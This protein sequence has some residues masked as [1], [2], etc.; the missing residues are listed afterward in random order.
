MKGTPPRV[1]ESLGE[2]ECRS[3]LATAGFGRLIFT[4][5]ALPVVEPVRFGIRRGQI[6]IPTG[7][8]DD[9]SPSIRGAV[10]AFEVDCLDAESGTGW[11][12]TA[13]GPAHVLTDEDDIADAERLELQPWVPSVNC[14]FVAVE[15][16]LLRGRRVSRVTRTAPSLV[17]G[18]LPQ[19]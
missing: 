18:V 15:I 11:T 3:L 5:H 4:R 16:R 8:D 9:L 12:V 17:A 13:V 2:L 7:S 19:S 1:T 14:C 10:V 6:L